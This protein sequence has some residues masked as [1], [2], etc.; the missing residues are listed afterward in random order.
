MK[1]IV[2]IG[3]GTGGS[4]IDSA[5]AKTFPNLVSVVTSFDDGGSSGILRK[6]FGTLP[7]GDIRRR[8]FAQKT[9]DNK[10]LEDLYN[11]RFGQDNSL[12]THSLGN[13]LILAATKLWGEKDGIKNICELFK[14]K[15][16]VLPITYDFADLAAKLE[17]GKTILG[18]DLVGRIPT[19]AKL[20]T[21]KIEKIYLTRETKINEEVKKE[22]LS[23]DYIVLCP[24]DF[25]GSLLCNFLVDGFK[26]SIKKSKAKIIYYPN[27]MTKAAETASFKL[28]DFINILEKYLGKPVDYILY[29]NKFPNK[30]LLD[31]YFKD[32]KAEFVVNDLGPGDKRVIELPLLKESGVIRHD[33]KLILNSFKKVLKISS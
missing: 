19:E 13:L 18:E 16:K 10:I 11:F 12:E 7:H 25:Y 20:E 8:I 2:T 15:G 4:I 28:S 31:K 26:E 6:E 3:G 21:R 5:L 27:I 22:I 23:A 17:N 1:K 9:V 33:A 32:E 29:N 24:G 30:K 14:I